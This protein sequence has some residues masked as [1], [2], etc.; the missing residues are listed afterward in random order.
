MKTAKY[1]IYRNLH[2]KNF[3]I[4]YKQKVIN[5]AS[6]ILLNNGSFSISEAMRQKVILEKRKNVHAYVIATSYEI[7][8]SFDISKLD[9]I[10]YNPYNLSSFIFKDNGKKVEKFNKLICYSNKLYFIS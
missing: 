4:K 5:R 10:Y 9:E 2:T 3:S 8:T 6:I 7:L 1:Y